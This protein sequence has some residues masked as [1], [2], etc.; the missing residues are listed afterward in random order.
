MITKS[1]LAIILSKLKL[2]DNPKL[3]NEQYP[4]DSEVAADVLWQAY[5]LGDIKDKLIADLGAGTGILGIG[6]LCLGARKVHFVEKD[7][8]AISILQKNI[9]EIEERYHA[10]FS[11]EIVHGDVRDFNTAVNIVIQNPPFGT[12]E[13]HA[14]QVF[15][16]T[17]F[18]ISP[19]VYS[20][21]TF[22]STQFIRKYAPNKKFLISH[23]WIFDF[24]L[25]KTYTFHKKDITRIKVGA[26]RFVSDNF[27]K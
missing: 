3:M 4:T 7:V 12:K 9:L 26:F 6:A 23:Q 27:K 13:K 24:P 15:L 5:M 10:R 18:R 20:F 19:V 11:Y 14:D 8:S 22:E 2:F 16:E 25:K 21:H 17:A 1:Q